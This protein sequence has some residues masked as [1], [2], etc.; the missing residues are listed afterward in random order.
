[1]LGR[2]TEVALFTER[3]EVKKTDLSDTEIDKKIKE[4]LNKFM[5][6]V[7]VEDV[8]DVSENPDPVLPQDETQRPEPDAS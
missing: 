7:D 4:K 5:G 2:V 6:V 8:S 3:I 1:M